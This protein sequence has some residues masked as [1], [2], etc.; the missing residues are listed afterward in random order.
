MGVSGSG[1]STVG[2][3]LSYRLG[4]SFYDADDFHP[5]E[6]IAKMQAGIPLTDSDRAS[7]LN[8]LHSIVAQTTKAGKSA[9]MACSALK[10][11]YRQQIAGEYWQKVEWIYL[12]GDYQTIEQRILRRRNHFFDVRLLRSQFDTLEEP[13][14]ALIFDVTIDS[15]I[16]AERVYQWAND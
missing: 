14:N 15:E 1:K 4:C 13:Q 5:P 9:V 16:I 10:T 12:R 2:K 8:T 6:N 7:W 3:L 11:Q